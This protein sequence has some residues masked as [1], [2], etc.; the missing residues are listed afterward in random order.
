MDFKNLV[1]GELKAKTVKFTAPGYGIDK[2]EIDAV[3]STDVTVSNSITSNPVEF[4]IAIT[5]N[6]VINPNRFRISA[7]ISE[8][9][10][11][12]GGLISTGGVVS[13]AIN[14]GKSYF[15]GHSP[16]YKGNRAE[17]FYTKINE[18]KNLKGT[19]DSL[20]FDLF[21]YPHTYRN[22]VIESISFTDAASLGQAIKFSMVVRE[23]QL[24][25][26]SLNIGVPYRTKAGAMSPT[27]KG[28]YLPN[29]VKSIL[30]GGS[31]F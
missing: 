13:D 23:I 4:G 8:Y 22:L 17:Q 26:T 7:V 14:T 6:V 12:L 3:V 18:L 31:L 16:T 30:G 19:G 25:T 2:V 20:L 5:D 11:Q 10:S 21:I 15:S 27:S 9:D 24:A 1:A 29:D 28:G